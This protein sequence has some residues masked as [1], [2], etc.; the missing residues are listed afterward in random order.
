MATQPVEKYLTDLPQKL[1]NLQAVERHP[2]LSRS[3]WRALDGLK[4]DRSIVIK[5][6][7]KGSCIVIEDR[8][9]YI[10][11]GE[12]HLADEDTYKQIDSDPTQKIAASINSLISQA[13]NKGYLSSDMRDYLT[14]QDPSKIRTQQIYFLKK[15]HKNPPTVRPI[16][17]GVEGPTEKI[18]SFIEYYLQPQ[19]IKTQS[20]TKDSTTILRLLEETSFAQDII[21]AT[22]DVT[23]L[24]TNIPHDEG[25][26]SALTHLYPEE[27][28]MPFPKEFTES[29]LRIILQQNAFEFNSKMYSQIKGTAM[30]TK[31]A[32]AYANLFLD[33][34]ERNFLQQQDPAP[35]LWK[36]YIDDILVIWNATKEEL[37][38]F[39]LD[40]NNLH[41]TIKFTS[42]ISSE[43]ITF[44]DLEI[45]KGE[46]FTTSGKLDSRPH[47]KPT[48]KFQYLSFNSAHPKSVHKG[49]VKGEFTRMLRN[50][51]DKDTF[52]KSKKKISLHLQQRGYPLRIRRE[53]SEQ[54]KFESRENTLREKDANKDKTEQP[55][56]FVI[57]FYPQLNQKA[58]R[59][60]L[61][62]SSEE[63]QTPRVS[64]CRNRNLSNLIVRARLPD[65]EEP[66]K[67]AED[68]RLTMRP[69]FRS[70]STP[71]STPLC[72]CCQM[73]SKKERVHSSNGRNSYPT[74]TGTNCNSRN[75]IYLIECN[76][77]NKKMYV[78][79]TERQLKER[80]AGHRA[81]Y[82]SRKN[83]PIYRHFRKKDHTL[84]H[85]RVTILEQVTK[86]EKLL[87][88]EDHWIKKLNTRIPKGLNS[89]YSPILN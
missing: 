11:E 30:G 45:Y 10:T 33:S 1:T 71:C 56:A 88:R 17:S 3:E 69:T 21:L 47:F 39:L 80:M 4:K 16:V 9:S 22:I 50:C 43:Q 37:E 6:A 58:L 51:S 53:I 72:T 59:E 75:I 57:N 42:D 86:K 5:K 25:I 77:C 67:T 15:I 74:P 63:I 46:R 24:Y 7:D 61:Q 36:R 60:A 54:V 79:E 12:K 81:A 78:G 41:P 68:I 8:D 73:M 84:S 48:N 32:P 52:E 20:Y 76:K 31:M 14:H 70:C 64:Y 26:E 89:K 2:N 65:T 18:S 40:L 34:L 62:P 29:L 44:L 49:L 27:E 19:V 35:V 83:M 82:R 85:F 23:A 87:E 38:K 13:H 28:E 55:P 66:A